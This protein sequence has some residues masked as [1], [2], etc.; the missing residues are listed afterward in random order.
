[1]KKLKEELIVSVES[2]KLKDSDIVAYKS[3][4]S[5]SEIEKLSLEEQN[6][7]LYRQISKLKDIKLSS[8]EEKLNKTIELLYQL[9]ES[10]VENRA[11]SYA[12]GDTICGKEKFQEYV[13]NAKNLI[14]KTNVGLDKVNKTLG[15]GL[16][17]VKGINNISKL[18]TG[19]ENE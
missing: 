13:A 12:V 15:I 18:C 5:Q 7:E 9:S 11:V 8:M 16:D 6:K 10:V 1:M 3:L 2:G 4:L 17:I 14:K 19:E